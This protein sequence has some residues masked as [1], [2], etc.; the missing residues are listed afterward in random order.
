MPKVME[1]GEKLE[2]IAS[3]RSVHTALIAVQIFFG[4]GSVIGALGL[5]AF[6]PLV[7]A[8]IREVCA[9]ALLVTASVVTTGLWPWDVRRE[10]VGRFVLLG[11][12]IF[13]NQ[14]GFIVGIKLANP[15]AASIWQPSQPIMTC[16]I[17]MALGWEPLNSKRILGIFIAFAGCAT[18]VA[19]DATQ[20]DSSGDSSVIRQLAGNI[21]FF[22]NCLCTALYVIL[23][24]RMLVIYPALCVSAWSYCY[25]AAI[26]AISTLLLSLS[27]DTMEFLCPDCKGSGYA[28]NWRVPKGSLW[29][30]AYWITINSAL[31][32]ALLTWANKYASSTLVMAYSVLQPV[33]AAI[34]TAL[35][36]ALGAYSNCKYLDDDTDNDDDD[37]ACLEPPGWA[38]L[39]A[40]GVFAGLYLIVTTEPSKEELPLPQPLLNEDSDWGSIIDGENSSVRGITATETLNSTG[41]IVFGGKGGAGNA[42]G[43]TIRESWS[44]LVAGG[45]P[46]GEPD[47]EGIHHQGE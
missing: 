4:C 45:I 28:S 32:Y 7:F 16:A 3:P 10:H 31:A 27:S 26:M 41:G 14:A 8:L 13:G 30:L 40:L 24:K 5:P 25:A 19:V 15:V 21:L 42:T 23:G 46:D 34:L 29:A 36:L 37:R 17:C 12:M 33:T 20:A 9:G 47:E 38:D 39:G 44:P 11:M 35:I 2:V 22:I 43:A 1:K 6:N 18:M